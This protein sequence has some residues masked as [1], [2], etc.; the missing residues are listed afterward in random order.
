[1]NTGAPA[2]AAAR[3]TRQ[4]RRQYG[5]KRKRIRC[6]KDGRRD[7]KIK[8]RLMLRYAPDSGA[9]ASIAG[10]SGLGHKRTRA[11]AAKCGVFDDPVGDGLRP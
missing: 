11:V 3:V 6:A 10:L 8:L 2:I 7:A 9:K 5:A 4:A 1:V